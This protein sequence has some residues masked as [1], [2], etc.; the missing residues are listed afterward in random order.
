[1]GVTITNH[2][3]P[4][5]NPSRVRVQL[6]G[7]PP[8]MQGSPL[9]K[10]L[11]M[12]TEVFEDCLNLVAEKS[13]GYGNA[14][15]EQGWMGNAARIMSKAARLKSMVWRDELRRGF[16]ATDE[17]IEDTVLDTVNLSLFF[18]LNRRLSN[19]WGQS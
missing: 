10:T 11:V 7:L 16:Y 17:S 14:W 18:L 13:V 6:T 1:M 9:H 4:T 3:G 2:E 15:Q 12:M 5:Y 19:K 8:E